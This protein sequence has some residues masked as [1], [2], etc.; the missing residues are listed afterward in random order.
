VR[1]LV[2]RQVPFLLGASIAAVL[3]LLSH[4]SFVLV[5]AASFV[6]ALVV[7]GR[8][9]VSPGSA[10]LPFALPATLLAALVAVNAGRFVIGGGTSPPPGTVLLQTASLAIGGPVEGR[11]WLLTAALAIL[12]LVCE[13]ARRIR[14]YWPNRASAEPSPLLWTFFVAAILV[15]LW[16]VT[17]VDPPFLYP[18]YFL[19]LVVFVPLLVASFVRSLR[20]PWPSLFIAAWLALNGWSF[21][22][23]TREGRGSYEEALRFLLESSNRGEVAIASDHD[24]RNG[25]VVRFYRERM[26]RDAERLRYEN[27]NES[28]EAEFWIGSYEGSECPGCPLLRSYPSSSLSGSRWRLYRKR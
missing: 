24:F 15:P 21:A 13:L 11:L 3:G 16:L 4:P 10:L 1:W 6:Y 12:L 2:T 20:G 7:A 23:F 8:G 28:G 25:T 19:V 5:L 27:A 22:R 18:R 26:G 14:R 9:G 17:I